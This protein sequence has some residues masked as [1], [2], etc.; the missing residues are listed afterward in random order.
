MFEYEAVR[1]FKRKNFLG[2]FYVMNVV[3]QE[4]LNQRKNVI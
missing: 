1:P 3:S 2:L 4:C